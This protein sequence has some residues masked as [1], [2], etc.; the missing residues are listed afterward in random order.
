MLTYSVYILTWSKQ[1]FIH[2]YLYFFRLHIYQNII[3]LTFR[4]LAD[5]E[6][7]RVGHFSLLDTA[8]STSL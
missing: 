5:K 2:A 3:V 1:S 6:C 7:L 4:K 8:D